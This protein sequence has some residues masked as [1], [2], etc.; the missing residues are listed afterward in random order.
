MLRKAS[1]IVVVL[2]SAGCRGESMTGPIGLPAGPTPVFLPAASDE[3]FTP[4]SDPAVPSDE[5][6]GSAV[7][8]GAGDIA[9]CTPDG[10]H[11]ETARLLDRI[12]GTVFALGDN[13]YPSGS[14]EQYRDCYDRTWGRHRG[15]TR[16]VAGN[17]EYDIA[18][19]SPY[20]EYF[21][22]SAGPY[23]LGYYSFDLGTWHIV[24]LNS[25]I[26]VSDGSAQGAWLRADLSASR[27]KCTLAY[28]H[29][30]RFSSGP[31]GDQGQMRKFWQI[32]HDAGA[33]IVLSA[34]DHTYERFAPQDPDG[35][36]D[37]ARGI[38]QFVVGTGGAR[39]YDFTT[40]RAN[41]EVRLSTLGVL[42]LT[43]SGG[44]YE[45]E[46]V[47]VSGPSDFGAALCH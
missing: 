12:S 9:L 4:A 10:R 23:G 36:P 47:S 29:H 39:P 32:L 44:R 35:L 28:W 5:Q 20:F 45:W 17:H 19:A 8:V 24:A 37:A 6:S 46:F 18:G 42:K 1:F 7:F 2:V 13:V 41:S 26:P 43:L 33:D 3:G 30:P 40:V 25:S 21:G 15:R 14:A 27:A 22:P 11:E 34:H 31:H 16:P 38:R